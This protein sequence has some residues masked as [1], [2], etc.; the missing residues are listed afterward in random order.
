MAAA[1]DRA[2][3]SLQK[4]I[5]RIP[6][7]QLRAALTHTFLT[8]AAAKPSPTTAAARGGA[9]APSPATSAADASSDA[10]TAST[11]SARTW[12]A[13]ACVRE[14]GGEAWGGAH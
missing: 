9:A 12:L 13:R 2:T 11:S 3:D 5:E 14:E 7:G 4:E 1:G 10:A 8:P 6:E